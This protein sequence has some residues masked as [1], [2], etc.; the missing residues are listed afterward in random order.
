MVETRLW[1]TDSCLTCF[2]TQKCFLFSFL[3]TRKV[4]VTW[5]LLSVYVDRNWAMEATGMTRLV[6][7][8]HGLLLS[9]N[10]SPYLKKMGKAQSLLHSA[11]YL[12]LFNNNKKVSCRYSF[13]HFRDVIPHTAYPING[14]WALIVFSQGGSL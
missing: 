12:A 14:C 9:W 7:S 13:I 6:C 11:E 1:A 10:F 2:D 4:W 3:Q 8:G 5:S